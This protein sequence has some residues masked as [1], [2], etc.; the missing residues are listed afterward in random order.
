MEEILQTLTDL[1]IPFEIQEHKAIFSEKDA[2]DVV[3][4]LPGIDVKNLFVKDKNNNYGLV[5]MNL[6]KRADLKKIAALFGYSRLSFCNPD[7]LKKYLD[8][9]P[10]SVSPLCIKADSEC[11]VKLFFDENFTGQKVI[12]HPLRNTASI[13]LEFSDL[14]RFAEKYGHSWILGNVYKEEEN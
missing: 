13:S 9:T 2:E 4:N 11:R 7:E 1:N 6:H 5:S 10:G 12:I 3:I 8:I 14:C